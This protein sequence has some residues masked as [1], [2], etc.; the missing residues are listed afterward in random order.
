M[1]DYHLP[2]A[3]KNVALGNPKALLEFGGYVHSS[4]RKHM[5]DYNLV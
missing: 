4:Q 5:P 3:E 2:A 1:H